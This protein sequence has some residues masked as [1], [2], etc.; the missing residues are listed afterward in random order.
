MEGYSTT[1]DARRGS[2]PDSTTASY[3]LRPHEYGSSRSDSGD[4]SRIL[5]LDSTEFVSNAAKNGM[6]SPGLKKNM[7]GEGVSVYAEAKGEYTRQLCQYLVPSLQS[8]FLDLLEDAKEKEPDS[9]K[10]LIQFQVL[11]EEITDWNVDKVQRET[12]EIITGTHC[13]YLD[14]LMTAVFIAH[15][16]VLSAIRLT[17]KQKKLNITIPKI[18]HF[19]HR[20]LT[21]C[22]RILWSNTYLFSASGTSIERQKN[23]RQ[24]ENCLTDGVLQAIRSML[25]VKSILREYL[26]EDPEDEE[27]EGEVG[28][29]VEEVA[30]GTVEAESPKKEETEKKAVEKPVEEVKEE[31][32]EEVKEELKKEEVKKEELKKEEAKKSSPAPPSQNQTI[33][34]DSSPQVLFSGVN[35]VFDLDNP[36]KTGFQEM[37]ADMDEEIVSGE[38]KL[39]DGAPME[40]FDEFEEFEDLEKE[41]DVAIEFEEL[42]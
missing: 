40:D 5:S 17:M 9:K 15:T 10:V 35:T 39:L 12:G 7:D 22:S 8:Y 23:M 21:E 3:N 32:K 4:W 33:V 24:I 37:N 20:T 26:K 16:K 2:L 6:R 41:P 31:A 18:D 38:I 34:V 28:L 11:L 13:D 1:T 36:D 29:E 42:S 19:I 27:E 14:E 25:P 30:P